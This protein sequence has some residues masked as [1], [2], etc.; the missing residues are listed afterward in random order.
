MSFQMGG[1]R[2]LTCSELSTN[3]SRGTT[4]DHV[5]WRKGSAPPRT[6]SD[7][8]TVSRRVSS[9]AL[10]DLFEEVTKGRQYTVTSDVT[11]GDRGEPDGFG[12]SSLV[13]LDRLP[14]RSLSFSV[15]GKRLSGMPRG[16]DVPLMREDQTATYSTVPYQ[17]PRNYCS[18]RL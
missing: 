5:D 10:V 8:D 16:F 11:K 14:W 4:P 1:N 18:T 15:W 9:F 3:I 17:G 6:I 7:R 13:H 2:T 12:K